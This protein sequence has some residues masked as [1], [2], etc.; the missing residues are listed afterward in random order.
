MCLSTIIFFIFI[1]NESKAYKRGGIKID[2][3]VAIA[4]TTPKEWA[5]G[6]RA[7]FREIPTD[8]RLFSWYFDGR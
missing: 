3:L 7:L 6:R 2:S 1:F 4:E 5:K 8:C